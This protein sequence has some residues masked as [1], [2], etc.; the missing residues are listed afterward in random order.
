[1]KNLLISAIAAMAVSAAAGE[2]VYV[3]PITGQPFREGGEYTLEQIKARDERVLKKTGGFVEAEAKGVSVLVLDTRLKPGGAAL[4]FEDVFSSLSKTN[5]KVER[6]PLEPGES[7]LDKAASMLGSE[8]AAYA[9]AI[10]EDDARRGLA[11]YPEDRLAV[12]NAAR[13]RGGDDPLRPEVRVHKEIWRALGFMAGIGYAPFENDVMQPVF[14]IGELDAQQYQV[15]QPMNFQKMYAT[16]KNF[17]VTRARRVPYRLACKEG[18][19]PAPTNEYQKAI[20]DEFH[21][22]PTKPVTIEYDPKRGM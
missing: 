13:Y 11:V 22:L 18:W 21:Q 7:A 14:S 6:K 16:L 9:I 4:Q 8:K 19:A 20:W 3:S 17:G 12:V 1:M 10:I 2:E 5:V 15:M